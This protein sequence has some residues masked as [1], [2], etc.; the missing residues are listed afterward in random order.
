[1]FFELNPIHEI[2]RL[3]H[4]LDFLIENRPSEFVIVPS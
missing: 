2:S 3:S 4:S 1:M